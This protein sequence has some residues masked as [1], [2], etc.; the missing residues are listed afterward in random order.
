MRGYSRRDL[1]KQTARALLAIPLMKPKPSIAASEESRLFFSAQ[2]FQMVD[3]L[4]ELILPADDHSPGA[5]EAKVA[6]YIDR[7]LAESFEAEPRQ[8]WRDG[9]ERIDALSKETH[10][11]SFLDASSGQRTVPLERLSAREANP[12][13]FEEIFF[14]ELKAR[15]VK[16]YYT[17]KV[18]IHSDMKYL[19]NTYLND[20]SGFDAK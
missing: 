18:G 5:R 10:G 9:L 3:K 19:G 7:R 20:F 4:S 14:K 16:A 11:R 12:Q 1:L 2:E 15:T 8:M 13:L 17:S 6:E